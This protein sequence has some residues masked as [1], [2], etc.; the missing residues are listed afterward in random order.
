MGQQR[1]AVL[2]GERLALLG[3]PQP[4]ADRPGG[5]AEDRP[6][7]RAAA[8]ADA[9]A[10][11]VEES[12]AHASVAAHLAD[13]TLGLVQRPVGG[14]EADV[15]VR[16]GVAEHHLLHRVAE[17]RAVLGQGEQIG[18]DRRG[19]LEVGEGLEQR[20]GE[21]READLAGEDQ[22]LEHVGDALGHA[23]DVAAERARADLPDGGRDLA[24]RA[25]RGLER[26]GQGHAGGPQRAP[27]AELAAQ[28]GETPGLGQRQVARRHLAGRE[29][30][31][32]RGTG[33][34]AV[35]AQVEADEVAAEHP[36]GR[37]QRRE[38]E[39]GAAALA[40]GAEADVEGAD[41]GVDVDRLALADGDTEGLELATE[42]RL[43]AVLLAEFAVGAA[44][45][46]E[47]ELART[48]AVELQ[49]VAGRFGGD[50]GVAVAIAAHPAAESQR[51][52]GRGVAAEGRL[53]RA[54]EVALQLRQGASDHLDVAEAALDLILDGGAQATELGGAP[55]D[56]DMR[57]H[58]RHG[59]RVVEVGDRVGDLDEVGA[60]GAA[61]HLGR[62]G[63]EGQTELHAGDQPLDVIGAEAHVTQL[64]HRLLEALPP[65]P[66]ARPQGPHPLALLGEVDELEV[67]RERPHQLL[68]GRHVEPFEQRPQR[69]IIAAGPHLTD[70]RA[71]PFDLLE[72]RRAFL[73]GEHLPERAT[74]GIH[75]FGEAHS[76]SIGE[77]P[78]TTSR[79]R[80]ATRRAASGLSATRATIRAALAQQA[81]PR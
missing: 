37:P 9:R 15:L 67:Q 10:A 70:Q 34:A 39:V 27:R 78:K 66:R 26:V 3:D 62:V 32:D 43:A 51:Q 14:E 33:Q 58:P 40:G 2:V 19:V 49:R 8:A 65:R 25:D 50:E 38:Q 64:D 23:D 47:Q 76:L 80:V 63:G 61:A 44:D 68:R 35:L 6:A 71:Q 30:L 75:I 60:D 69:A 11:T 73:F 55:Q 13:V 45:A 74:E 31:G 5:L 22:R 57:G 54:P 46:G 48:L 20:H 79:I 4:C 59:A 77:R 17:D 16:V 52:R 53:E 24:D 81:I 42:A 1:V 56:L 36:R 21:D 7:R 18:H 72:E 29:Q 12:P 41:A 28:Q